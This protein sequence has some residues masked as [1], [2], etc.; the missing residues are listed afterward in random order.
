MRF[1]ELPDDWWE[2]NQKAGAV[3]GQRSGRRIAIGNVVRAKIIGVDIPARQLNLSMADED[4]GGGRVQ[5]R[6]KPKPHE[7]R[8]KASR[9][10]RGR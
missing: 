10:K 9:Q 3:V 2:F 6:P 4:I 1:N 8:R 5:S 7:R